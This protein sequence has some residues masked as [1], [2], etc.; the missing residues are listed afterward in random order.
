MCYQIVKDNEKFYVKNYDGNVSKKMSYN[1]C[2]SLLY[3][4]V[5]NDSKDVFKDCNII[6]DIAKSQLSSTPARSSHSLKT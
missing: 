5:L 4:L 6:Y 1:K 2:I 3:K